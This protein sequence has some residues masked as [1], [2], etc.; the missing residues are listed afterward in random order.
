M[1]LTRRHLLASAAAGLCVPV[2]HAATPLVD[3]LQSPAYAADLQQRLGQAQAPGL[4]MAVVDGGEV[5][6]STA[7]GWADLAAQRPMSP[8]T[9]LG[10]ASV[11]KVFTCAAVLQFQD[12]GRLD[13][14]APVDEWLSFKLRH[15]SGRP[16]TTRQLLTHTAAIADGPAYEASYACGDPQTSLGTWL[17]DAV[18]A[19]GQFHPWAPGERHAYSNVGYGLLGLLVERLSGQPFAAACKRT[20]LAPLGMARSRFLVA[21]LDRAVRATPYEFVPAGK[22]L[23]THLLAAEPPQA[24]DGGQ[25]VPLCPYSFAT[26]SDGMLHSSALELARFALAVLG[27]GA[28]DGRRILRTDTV[29]AMLSDQQA[30]VPE[31][32]GYR[33][34]L[35]WRGLGGGMWAHFGRDPGVAAALQIHPASGRGVVLL[36]NGSRARPLVAKLAN[37]VVAWRG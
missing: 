34:G 22:P 4:A 26:V 31:R 18:A 30:P 36:S 37:E 3:W 20:V 12:Q 32:A 16:I 23:P 25:Q 21:G 11:T 29:A 35:A 15:P 13:L 8:S 5:V 2:L 9:L 6:H 27:G 10:T 14:D 28:L 1:P 33:Q 17:R 7:F 19:G 24:V